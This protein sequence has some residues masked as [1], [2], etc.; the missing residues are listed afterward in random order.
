[1]TDF[2]LPGQFASDNY[3]GICPEVWDA[4]HAAD[5]GDAPAYGEDAW[6]KE[7]SDRFRELFETDCDVFMVFNGTAANSLSLASLCESFESLLCSE[8]AHIETDECGAPEFF[9]NGSKVLLVPGEQGK[10]DPLQAEELIT[11]RQDIHYP[12]PRVISLTQSTEVGTRYSL[13]ELAAIRELAQKHQLR[14]HMDGARFANAVVASGHSPAELTWKSGV[15]VLCF[16]GTKNGMGIG[17]AV[18]FFNRKLAESFAYRCKQAGQLASKMRYISAAW[19]GLLQNDV[20]MK[21]AAHANAMAQRLAKGIEALEGAH[22]MFPVQSNAVFAS[23]P[24]PA[25]QELRRLDW[26]FYTFIGQGGARFVC[27]WNT[28]PERVDELLEAMKAAL[29]STS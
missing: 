25:L 27:S 2:H 23:L 8:L 9:S 10:I 17:E 13:D 16:C 28:R 18:I 29:K 1:M 15:D 14:I 24:P 6:T 22:L 4:M 20:W 3:S 7:V 19:Q 12:R 26:R 21:N 5:Q 11:R